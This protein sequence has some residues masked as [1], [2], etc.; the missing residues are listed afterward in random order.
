MTVEYRL[1]PH[2]RGSTIV[3]RGDLLA[4]GELG[5]FVLG[6]IVFRSSIIRVGI[7]IAL[8][9]QAGI[10]RVNCLGC[11]IECVGQ[12]ESRCSSPNDRPGSSCRSSRSDSGNASDSNA[13]DSVALTETQ[14][15]C[16][17]D[18]KS[19]TLSESDA[20][21]FAA[22]LICN[23]DCS[24]LDCCDW[25]FVSG[26]DAI[27]EPDR[28]RQ[29]DRAGDASAEIKSGLSRHWAILFDVSWE[30]NTGRN[31]SRFGIFRS[32]QQQNCVWRN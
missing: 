19:H 27:N 18:T 16:R 8:L 31:S 15:C 25:E 24:D 29:V 23:P 5:I 3:E 13:R 11:S 20:S 9:V 14:S 10:P 17:L 32:L 30:Q 4:V 26:P 1:T 28:S 22:G 12:S 21:D 6:W 7:V 2:P